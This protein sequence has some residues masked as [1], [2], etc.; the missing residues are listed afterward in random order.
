MNYDDAFGLSLLR[1]A[2]DPTTEKAIQLTQHDA[3][4]AHPFCFLFY[5]THDANNPINLIVPDNDV[6]KEE[7]KKLGIFNM[8]HFEYTINIGP[9]VRCPLAEVIRVYGKPM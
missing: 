8:V 3:P 1:F 7:A 5:H 9:L 6:M 2:A 4:G